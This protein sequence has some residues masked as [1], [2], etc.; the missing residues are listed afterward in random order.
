MRRARKGRERDEEEDLKKEEIA[1][2]H[3]LVIRG[4]KDE[5]A[6]GV[7]RTASELW[8]YGGEMIKDWIWGFCNKV[9]KG[10]G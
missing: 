10:K 8:K 5:K 1:L 7:D 3:P 6:A 4:I 9:W 2:G